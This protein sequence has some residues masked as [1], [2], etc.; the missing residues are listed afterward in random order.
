[1]EKLSACVEFKN[2]LSEIDA[3]QAKLS[4]VLSYELFLK[5]SENNI[6]IFVDGKFAH[7]NIFNFSVLDTLGFE[8]LLERLYGMVDVNR[9]KYVNDIL[10]NMSV[11]EFDFSAIFENLT[12]DFSNAVNRDSFKHLLQVFPAINTTY[13]EVPKKTLVDLQGFTGTTVDT[14]AIPKDPKNLKVKSEDIKVLLSKCKDN[15][16]S[17]T[18]RLFFSYIS[19]EALVTLYNYAKKFDEELDDIHDMYHKI[20]GL[21]DVVVISSYDLKRLMVL[22]RKQ[23]KTVKEEGEQG[24]EE[25]LQGKQTLKTIGENIEKS[26]E[27]YTGFV[28]K[29]LSKKV[30]KDDPKKKEK[31]KQ[32]ESSD[33]D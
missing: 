18:R 23:L 2:K 3:D 9:T 21:D 14:E 33:E 7:E 31:S 6:K 16:K 11:P 12:S 17:R 28:R 10:H 26:L 1:M 24:E 30:K 4:N 15:L 29:S 27:I 5:R 20:E 8:K 25:E 19:L 13:S 22:Y 32:E